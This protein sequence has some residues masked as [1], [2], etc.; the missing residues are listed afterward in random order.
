MSDYER[1][2]RVIRYLDAHHAEQPDLGRLAAQAGLSVYHFHRLFSVWAGVTPKDF[3]RCLTL[4]HAKQRLREG[5]SVLSAALAAGVSGPSR[6]H[7]LCV[8]FEAAT[9]GEVK[10]SGRGWQL[11]F[12]FASSPFG[13]CILAEGPRGICY[14]A[15]GESGE[16]REAEARLAEAWPA[17][18]RK[19]NDAAAVRLADRV[20]RP[21]PGDEHEVPLRA[22][23]TGSAF[24]VR[25][26]QALLR[27][28]A[29]ALVSYGGLAKAM[30]Q[31]AAARAVG[32]A[33]A[34]NRLAYLI[35]CHRV[36]RETGVVGEYRWGPW[37][38]RA[39][40]AWESIPRQRTPATGDSSVKVVRAARSECRVRR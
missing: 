18:V 40:I 26:W 35:P 36:I 13:E 8:K 11:E 1:I 5:E 16:R 24:Q 2:A 29:G 25:V 38:K 4:A 12:G 9:P 37:R 23:V 14:L 19:R 6:L 31:P 34:A 20:F 3:L 15:F 21:A 22:M 30:G 17:A 33:V 32:S 39:L 10:S 7:D 27:V 28:P